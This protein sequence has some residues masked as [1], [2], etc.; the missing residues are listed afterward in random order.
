[1]ADHSAP[2][3]RNRRFRGEDPEFRV[4]GIRLRYCRTLPPDFT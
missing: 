3:L 2:V 1:L 4:A